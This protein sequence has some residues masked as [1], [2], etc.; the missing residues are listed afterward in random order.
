MNVNFSVFIGE[1]KKE[2]LERLRELEPNL[3]LRLYSDSLLLL[4]GRVRRPF[5]LFLSLLEELGLLDWELSLGC[6][7][8]GKGEYYGGIALACFLP[9]SLEGFGR[10]VKLGVKDSKKLKPSR[11]IKLARELERLREE[12]LVFYKVLSLSLE[13]YNSLYRFYRNQMRMLAALYSRLLAEIPFHT[14]MAEGGRVIIDGNPNKYMRSFSVEGF[15]LTFLKRGERVKSVAAA[16]VL[17]R[18]EFLSTLSLD[19]FGGEQGDPLQILRAWERGIDE[20]LLKRV[21]KEHFKLQT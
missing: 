19:L 15:K 8:S 12:G 6:D 5:N 1:G 13:D 4:Q 18:S 7:E 9:L 14:L 21:K 16:S 2:V 20:D 10:V 11:I 3:S 17:A